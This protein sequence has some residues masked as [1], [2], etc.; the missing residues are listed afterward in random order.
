M[1]MTRLR[2]L[3]FF[4]LIQV[5]AFAQ[6]DPAPNP[7]DFGKMWT[8]ENPPLE[9]LKKTY[10]FDADQE[11]FDYV[12]KSSLRF[13]TWCSASFISPE[14]LIM[15]NHHCSRDVV[16]KLQQEGENFDKSGF[17]AEKAE[18][19]RRASGLFV[20]QLIRV[21]DI[22]DE[23]SKAAAGF[24][25]DEEKKK[26]REAK[27]EELRDMYSANPDW[28]GL[29]IQTVSLYSGA[30]FSLYGYKRFD[31]I[32]LVW[33]PELDLGFYGG[34]PDNF[35]YPRYNLDATFWR[36]YDEDG[37]PANTSAHY[38]KFNKHGA[39][40]DELVFVVGNPGR[41]ER[42]RTVS[43]LE[44]DRD[45]RY[46]LLHRFLSNRNEFLM[47]EYNAM[48]ED[49]EKEF[50]AQAL[51]NQIASVANSMK[52][53][54][55]ISKGLKDP[56]LFGRKV[57]MENYIRSKSKHEE[58]WKRMEEL[59]V[60]LN[61][62]GWAVTHLQPS[63]LR[64]SMHAMLS[65]LARYNDAVRDSAPEMTLNQL[66][67]RIMQMA[68]V[69]QEDREKQL[70]KIWLGE[71]EADIYPGDMT[72]AKATMGKST[73]DFY[74]AIYQ[75]SILSSK[76]KLS[77]ALEKDGLLPESD[78]AVHAGQVFAQKL[79]YAQKLFGASNDERNELAAKIAFEAY[80]VYGSALPPDATFTLRITDGQIKSYEYNGTMA[81]PF[82]TYYGM[83]DRHHSHGAVFPW[84]LPERWVNNQHPDLLKAPLNTVSTNDIIG[85]NSGSPLINKNKEVVGLVFDGNIESLPGNFIFDDQYNRSVSV[86]S[87][88]MYAALK[89][90]YKAERILAELEK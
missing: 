48:K 20:E 76:E 75:N 88:G 83:Y 16:N 61:P 19:E 80:Q 86:H 23:I 8:F 58:Y 52:A 45:H 7:F 60:D 41:T 12:R 43:Q 13:A 39:A 55:G 77:D 21:V 3:L 69:I 38:L 56:E 35:T 26:A 5:L 82:T 87:A 32:R 17:Y 28:D 79:A 78:P 40:E 73:E 34:D 54:G 64:G 24:N 81:P 84:S 53:F 49:P 50:E 70:F 74:N 18:D 1:S 90:I 29:R 85:G 72:L 46:P 71:V 62:N 9:H 27:L 2:I 37:N 59:Y 33:L 14:G 30:R 42:Y 66:Q 89:Y 51:L 4:L 15:T 44:F 67:G 31:D 47:A 68:E 6:Q 36:A 25:T 63:Q 10:N 11:W 65:T 22:S 57:S